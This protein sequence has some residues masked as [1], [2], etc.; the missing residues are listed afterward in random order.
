MQRLEILCNDVG[1]TLAALGWKDNRPWEEFLK[2]FKAPS[3]PNERVWT[4]FL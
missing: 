3:N 4:N 2:D 1:E